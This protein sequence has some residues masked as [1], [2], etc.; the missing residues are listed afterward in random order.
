MQAFACSL[1]DYNIGGGRRT[2]KYFL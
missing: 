1:D 2:S